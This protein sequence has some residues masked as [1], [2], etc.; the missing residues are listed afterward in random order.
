MAR[1]DEAYREEAPQLFQLVA[2][3]A[4]QRHDNWCPERSLTIL[5]LAFDEER[6]PNFAVEAVVNFTDESQANSLCEQ[7]AHR[8]ISRCGGLLEVQRTTGHSASRP[9]A[10]KVLYMHRTVKGYI[11][12]DTTRELLRSRTGNQLFNPFNPD[13]AILRSYVLQMKVLLDS[14]P[15]YCWD[16]ISPA[17][18]F[19]RWTDSDD[20]PCFDQL[21]RR[22]VGFILLDCVISR[23]S[24][25]STSFP[26]WL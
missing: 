26:A 16:L 5:G 13:L 20:F 10:M 21:A 17:I 14:K 6:K 24:T 1:V 7:M 22:L 25:K 11:E 23:T 18:T 12:H 2:T 9:S 19:A 3:A 15:F 4:S 8:L